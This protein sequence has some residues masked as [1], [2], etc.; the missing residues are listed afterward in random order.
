MVK[1]P[2]LVASDIGGT[3]THGK[4]V[5]PGFTCGVL[6]RLI[7]MDIPV[8][9]ITGFNYHAARRYVRNLDEQITLIVQNG[10]LCEQGGRIVWE[11]QIPGNE[12]AEIYRF[13]DLYKIPIIV[14][15]GKG[16]DFKVLCKGRGYLK[17]RPSLTQ[18]E[19][20]R[21]FHGVTGISTL[22]P[23]DRVGEIRSRIRDSIQ[24]R[25]QLIR[26]LGAELSWLEITPPKARKDLALQQFCREISIPLSDVI[27]FGDNY[28]DSHAL[29]AVGYPVVMEN[30]VAELKQGFE[31]K[32]KSVYEEGAAHY[33]V[34]LFELPMEKEK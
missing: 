21:D 12:A 13:L 27:Y 32:A 16:E 9:L 14:Y 11:L 28:N 10:A 34:Q 5:I 17:D 25:F 8:V 20:V 33:L 30:A 29:H 31:V 23:T 24:D 7:S 1:R 26:S 22:V 3:L 15:K 2:K 19:E 6:N 4:N 18:V